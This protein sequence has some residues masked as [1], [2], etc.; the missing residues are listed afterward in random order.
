MIAAAISRGDFAQAESFVERTFVSL[1][2]A[3]EI[4]RPEDRLLETAPHY[5]SGALETGAVPKLLL[6]WETVAVQRGDQARAAACRLQRFARAS[7]T[8]GSESGALNRRLHG[9]WFPI[10]HF[11][12]A[13]NAPPYL[14]A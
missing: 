4:W 11:L 7:A 6:I 14:P 3:K 9:R 1:L 10:M 2:G 13:T 12:T 8:G 5:Y